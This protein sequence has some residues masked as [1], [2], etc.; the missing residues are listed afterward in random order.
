VSDG[1]VLARP[2]VRLFVGLWLLYAYGAMYCKETG[3]GFA[4]YL[5]AIHYRI[6]RS[7]PLAPYVLAAAA[8][9][10]VVLVAVPRLRSHGIGFSTDSQGSG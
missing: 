8:A 5:T 9:W 3:Y 6:F 1:G 4:H 2:G 10:I 7:Y